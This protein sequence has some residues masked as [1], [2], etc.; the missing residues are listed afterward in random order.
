VGFVYG[1]LKGKDYDRCLK[2]GIRNAESVI[3]KIGA[4]NCLLYKFN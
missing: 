2:Y 4:K 1:I 3:Q